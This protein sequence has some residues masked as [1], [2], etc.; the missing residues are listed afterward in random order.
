VLEAHPDLCLARIGS[1]ITPR[2]VVLD[3]QSATALDRCGEI[4]RGVPASL[5]LLVGAP[6]EEEFAIEALRAGARGI[7]PRNAGLDQLL[8]A[9]RVVAEGQVWAET[10]IVT[11]ALDLLSA[12]STPSRRADDS[13]EGQLTLRE[14]EIFRHTMGGLNNRE[15]AERMAISPATVKAHLTSV[16]RKLD[17]RDRT[18]LVVHYHRPP[19]VAHA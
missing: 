9:I 6:P 17:V 18:Q 8:K 2:V 10:R 4:A 7:L 3:A 14:R 5:V 12:L 16:F 1:V 13:P 11:R 19:R 15:I